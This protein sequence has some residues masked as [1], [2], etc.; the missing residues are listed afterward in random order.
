MTINLKNFL[1]DKKKMS[2]NVENRSYKLIQ[3]NCHPNF[4]LIDLIDEKKNIDVSQIREMI[5]YTN[6]SNFNDKPRFI[7]DKNIRLAVLGIR[8]DS[9]I[10]I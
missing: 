10:S 5:M 4:Y 2:I 9:S 7:L 3:N 6:K 8:N 1:N